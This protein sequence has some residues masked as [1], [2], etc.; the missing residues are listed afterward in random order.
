[1]KQRRRERR[2]AKRARARRHRKPDAPE[3]RSFY[4]ALQEFLRIYQFRDRDRA[5]YG[6]VTP[7][8]CYAL[9]AIH[10]AGV[11]SVG[12]LAAALR[13]HKSNAGR[14]AATLEE[15]GLVRRE[16]DDHDA[17][18]VRLRLTGDGARVHDGI[19]ARVESRQAAILTTFPP[20]VRRA[21]VR[22]LAALAAEATGRVGGPTRPGD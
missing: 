12:A 6:S 14:L 18:G 10:R 17:R 7:H 19:R 9:E 3:R 11:L 8:E 13:L 22:L 1:M 15:R 16:T 2:T 21:F 5:C 4:E 20:G